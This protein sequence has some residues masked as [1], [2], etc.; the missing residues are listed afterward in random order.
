M[1]KYVPP[2]RILLPN[3]KSIPP[4][5]HFYHPGDY[6]IP[7]KWWKNYKQINSWEILP[8]YHHTESNINLPTYLCWEKLLTGRNTHSHTANNIL[9][10][11]QEKTQWIPHDKQEADSK[12]TSANYSHGWKIWLSI[13][14]GISFY[15]WRDLEEVFW[16]TLTPHKLSSNFPP[17]KPA[18][19]ET[20]Y[21][22]RKKITY[23]HSPPQR[24]SPP[25][26][27]C[28]HLIVHVTH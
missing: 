23:S 28:L 17:H 9:V 15:W 6:V 14:M 1:I 19:N 3:Y 24:P 10:K 4:L 2:T 5:K 12:K 8:H 11:P 22:Q 21:E 18:E 16:N 13:H 25:P 26:I 27:R 20:K 7:R